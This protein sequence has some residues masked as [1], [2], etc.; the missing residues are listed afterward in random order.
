LLCLDP[1][2]LLLVIILQRPKQK[3]TLP[4]PCHVE[5]ILAIRT[6]LFIRQEFAEWRRGEAATLDIV[7]GT[8]HLQDP[9]ACDVILQNDYSGNHEVMEMINVVMVFG[10]GVPMIIMMMMMMMMMM[11]TTMTR[12]WSLIHTLFM[13]VPPVISFSQHL[14]CPCIEATNSGVCPRSF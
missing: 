6:D 11:T 5:G 2:L 14:T 12:Y 3:S 8:L 13:S 9:L 10:N 1:S 4:G 7:A